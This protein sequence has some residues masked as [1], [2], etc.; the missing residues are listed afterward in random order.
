MN[1]CL[2]ASEVTPFAKTG[3]LADVAAAL[4][5]QL[6]LRGHAVRLF[7]PMYRRV[8]RG[9]WAFV[10][11]P[12]LQD[13]SI[14]L[15]EKPF[16]FSVSTARLPASE[17]DVWFVR[18]PA[19]YDRDELYGEGED[20]HL[21]FAL[22]QRAALTALQHLGWSPD[23]VHA[24]DWHA[25][26]LP[27][28]VRHF[29]SWDRLFANTKTVLTIHNI[30]FQG[31]FGR[32]VLRDLDL[33]ARPELLHQQHLADGQISF[34]ETGVLY[35]DAVTTV[36]RTY[37]REI[38]TSEFGMG[39][40]Q[41]LRKRSD[42]LFGIVNGIDAGEWDPATDVLIPAQYTPR[43]LDGKLVCKRQLLERMGLEFDPRAC[44][45]GIVSRLT[46][47]KGFELLPDVLPVFLQ[48]EDMRLVV[49][50]SGEERYEKYFAWLAAT[51][52]HKVA[53][54]SGYDEEL[55]HWIEAGSDAFLM[56]SRF[57]PCGLNQMYSLKY[58]TVPVV[59]ATGGLADTVE[60][61][62]A[63]QD[64]GTGFRFDAFTAEALQAAL[65]QMFAVWRDRAAWGRLQ[66]R[67]MRQDTSWAAQVLE[68]ENLYARLIE[69]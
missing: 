40:E 6:A 62:D 11:H 66:Q 50:G 51:Y 56:P 12:D 44:T 5:R 53:F 32:H 31:T 36:S 13:L 18:C 17:A 59:R 42:T 39:L 28:Y 35:A 45:L 22:L 24:H 54:R 61:Y 16:T 48:R 23:V 14:V 19:L 55:A 57:E 3:G 30:A 68:Y 26:L 1:L 33:D 60:P 38:Q 20:E 10:P 8:R 43:K 9:G 21:R 41:L 27:L 7:M 67:G 25:G 2:V 58:G 65:E 34:L 47:Q 46:F 29:M 69:S 49:L 64:T 15:G 52:P 63:E 4:T 37:A